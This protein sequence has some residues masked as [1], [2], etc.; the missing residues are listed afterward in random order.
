MTRADLRVRLFTVAGLALLVL[1]GALLVTHTTGLTSVDNAIVQWVFDVRGATLPRLARTVTDLGYFGLLLGVTVGVGLVLVAAGAWT[2]A[3]RPV[4]ALLLAANIGH[5]L[6]GLVDRARPASEWWYAAAVDTAPGPGYPSGHSGQSAAAWLAIA[7][8]LGAKWPAH[9]A[10]LL[11]AAVAVFVLVGLSR[12]MLGVHSPS[13][14]IAGWSLG[15]ACAVLVA[16]S[17]ALRRG[18]R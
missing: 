5:E 11:R 1:V 2:L 15:I 13:D 9:R 16:P 18:R 10:L 14:V 7:L 3:W 6:K 8:V 12:V 17:A 4:A